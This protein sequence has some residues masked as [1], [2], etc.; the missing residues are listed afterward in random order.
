M[1][2]ALLLTTLVVSTLALLVS[3]WTAWNL[4]RKP[5]AT[6]HPRSTRGGLIIHDGTGQTP[7]DPR[8]AGARTRS[9]TAGPRGRAPRPC[10]A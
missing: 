7:G 4:H 10:L 1:P 5:I 2:R 8:R 6:A 9:A 3:G